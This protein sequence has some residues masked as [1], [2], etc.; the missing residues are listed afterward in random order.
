MYVYNYGNT[1]LNSSEE[2]IIFSFIELVFVCRHFFGKYRPTS[3]WLLNR[4]FQST[5]FC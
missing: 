4:M 1:E 2:S 5:N 3:F